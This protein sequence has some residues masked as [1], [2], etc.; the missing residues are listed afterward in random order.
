LCDIYSHQI[1]NP[2]MAIDIAEKLHS[3]SYSKEIVKATVLTGDIAF[4]QAQ[5]NIISFA[6]N[7]WWHMYNIACVPDISENRYTTEQKIEIM[8]RGIALFEVIFDGNYLYYND[9]LAN[10]YRQLAMLYLSLGNRQTALECVEKMA[11]HAIE[12][13]SLADAQNYSGVLINTIEYDA[14]KPEGSE[15]PSLCA[16][17]LRGRFNARIWSSIRNEQRFVAAVE[18][19]TEYI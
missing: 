9:R 4:N 1:G 3:M 12:F 18:R 11:D 8:Q 15:A 17:L 2:Q 14:T 16:K 10:S 7:I 6:D 13:D 19:M 5:R